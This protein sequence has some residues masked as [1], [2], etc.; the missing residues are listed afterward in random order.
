MQVGAELL[1]GWRRGDRS[2][3]DHRDPVTGLTRAYPKHSWHKDNDKTFSAAF[4][5]TTITAATTDAEMYDEL[6]D[7]VDMIFAQ[8]E[9]ARHYCRRI[10]RYFVGGEITPTIE[11]DIIEPLATVLRNADYDLP[12]ALKVLFKSVFFYENTQ[13]LSMLRAPLELGLQTLS[14]LD[15][16]P[17]PVSSPEAHYY[18]FWHKGFYN[19]ICEKASMRPFRPDSV[20][21]YPA[22]YQE[23]LFHRAWFTS[24]S[25]IARYKMPYVFIE[26]K[27]LYNSGTI[28]TQLDTVALVDTGG[29]A[30]DPSDPALLVADVLAYLFGR[31]PDADRLAYFESLLLNGFT[32]AEW[33]QEWDAYKVSKDPSAVRIHLDHLFYGILYSQ[34]YQVQ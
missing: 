19:S 33:L 14:L 3:P 28:G 8:A 18:D 11:T 1:T 16:A 32:P 15:V 30:S 5:Q 13:T 23:P 22:Y 34:E 12:T 26:G 21:G 9:T 29:M 10:Y 31:T 27:P 20:A 4:Q 17:P 25:I 7:Y 6:Q 2:N 24:A